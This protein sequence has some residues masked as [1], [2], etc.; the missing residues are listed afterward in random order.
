MDKSKKILTLY[1]MYKSVNKMNEYM[2][3]GDFENAKREQIA[4]IAIRKNFVEDK[5]KW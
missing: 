4:Q 2:R 1:R 3:L 5:R